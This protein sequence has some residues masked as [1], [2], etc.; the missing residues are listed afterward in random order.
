MGTA[1]KHR[2]IGGIPLYGME[3]R[4]SMDFHIYELGA[5]RNGRPEQPHGMTEI[6]HRHD[7]YEVMVFL[8]AGGEHLIDFKNYP[9]HG[10][11]LHFIS[12]GQV[13]LT[14]RNQNCKAFLLVFSANVL[15]TVLNMPRK[16]VAL[17]YYQVDC[18]P[19]LQPAPNEFKEYAELTMKIY[20]EYHRQNPLREELIR[21]YLNILLLRA[22]MH[23]LEAHPVLKVNKSRYT[24]IF[25]T[26]QTLIEAHYTQGARVGFYAEKLHISPGHLSKVSK[27]LTGKS[28]S[29]HLIDRLVLEGKRLLSTV[30][31]T[32]KEIAGQLGFCDTF[33]FNRFFKKNTGIT[34]GAFRTRNR[35]YE[36]SEQIV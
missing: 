20:H 13:H 7:F 32:Q 19:V 5:F 25:S 31:L 26:F 33:Y 12:P 22:K 23:Y 15:R 28:A 30:N 16:P 1:K 11:S 6:P 18:H 36:N 2:L 14:T 3:N 29:A 34:P 27:S 24:E 10:G 8:T 9:I 21:G 4:P 35:A 17:P